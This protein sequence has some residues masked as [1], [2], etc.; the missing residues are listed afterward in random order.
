MELQRFKQ[1]LKNH[2][3]STTQPRLRLFGH[4]QG[5]PALTMQQLIALTARHDR[6]TVYRNVDL[7]EKLGIIN[8]LRLGWHTK[9]ELSDVFQRHHHHLSCTSCGK[10]WVLE[11][12]P[13]IEQKI[14]AISRLKNFVAIDHQLEIRGTCQSCQKHRT[15]GQA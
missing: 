9:I 8:R 7:F 14:K 1:L 15:P 6:V 3:L 10:V 2:G 11:E 4:L 5:N 13:L 12:E